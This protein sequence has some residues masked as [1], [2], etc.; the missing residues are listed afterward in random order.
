[1]RSVIDT[2]VLICGTFCAGPPLQVLMSCVEGKFPL[3]FSPE[4]LKKSRNTERPVSRD[5]H[6][7]KFIA[8]ALAVDVDVIVSGDRDLLSISEK[9]AVP[10]MKPREFVDRYMSS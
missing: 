3:V 8:C 5:P 7:D 2:D 6:D 9:L 1:M 10:V 4:I